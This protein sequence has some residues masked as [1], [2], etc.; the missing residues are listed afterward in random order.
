M[1]SVPFTLRNKDSVLESTR[2]PDFAKGDGLLPAIA[3]DHASGRV[4]MLA[5][6]NE[7][8]FDETLRRGKAVYFSRSRNKL[9]RKGEQ[10]GHQQTVHEIRVD[11]D[12]D[13]ILLMV[14]QVGAACHE[15][16]ESCFFRTVSDQGIEVVDERLKDPADIYGKGGSGEGTGVPGEGT[17]E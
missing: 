8:A 17:G 15:G 10:S 5:W 13:T 6:M 11:C 9:W 1:P 4:L 14:E 12:A 2:R 3:Q 7:E 16:Y